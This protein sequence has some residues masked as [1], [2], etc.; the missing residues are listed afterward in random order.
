MAKPIH[1]RKHHSLVKKMLYKDCSCKGSVPKKVSARKPQ[2]TWR[3]VELTGIKPPVVTLTWLKIAIFSASRIG[4]QVCEV[5]KQLQDLD[6]DMVLF[7]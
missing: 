6:T 3:Q 5:R 4:R 7:S 2:G 1:K